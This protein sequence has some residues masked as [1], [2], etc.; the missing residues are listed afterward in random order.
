MAGL[1]IVL[2]V[3][4]GA[5]AQSLFD[6]NPSTGPALSRPFRVSF[7][8]PR[9]SETLRGDVGR[10]P[11]SSQ[12]KPSAFQMQPFNPSRRRYPGRSGSGAMKSA[13]KVTAAVA[14]G[15]VGTL[16]GALAGAV[17]TRDYG[18]DAM[19]G[20]LIGAPIG[21]AVGAIVGYRLV[22]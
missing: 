21:A 5:S 2:V 18:D 3:S 9:A 6:S 10:W 22:K 17:V 13:Q 8:A 12:A 7:D 1:A 14:L 16:A 15:L 11:L 19:I 4:P 20:P